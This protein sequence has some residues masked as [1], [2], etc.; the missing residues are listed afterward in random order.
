[1]L[2]VIQNLRKHR[3]QSKYVDSLFVP[4]HDNEIY[5]SNRNGFRHC[6]SVFGAA[7]LT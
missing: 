7:H 1:M 4:V 6:Q 5:L 2:E 3:K